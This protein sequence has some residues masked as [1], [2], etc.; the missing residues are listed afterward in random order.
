MQCLRLQIIISWAASCFCVTSNLLTRDNPY[1]SRPKTIPPDGPHN[2]PHEARSTQSDEQSATVDVQYRAG[3]CAKATPA[4]S[5][6]RS[7]PWS[8]QH[9]RQHTPVLPVTN[10]LLLR[11]RDADC[12]PQ[13]RH[14]DDFFLVV[15]VM[16]FLVAQAFRQRDQLRA[17]RG[18]VL[19]PAI[20]DRA[21]LTERAWREALRDDPPLLL[22]RPEISL[23]RALGFAA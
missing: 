10:G 4:P 16:S 6:A 8:G 12:V 13:Q 5:S 7:P 20:L 15:T 18:R 23:A 1:L 17:T 21:D 9:R 3:I 19:A 22:R 11:R 2:P 14:L